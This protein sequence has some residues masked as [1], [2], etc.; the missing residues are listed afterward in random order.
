[1]KQIRG[2]EFQEVITVLSPLIKKALLQTSFEN[3]DD[4]QQE[5]YEFILKKI[6]NN[7]FTETVDFFDLLEKETI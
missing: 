2:E 3:R 4:L 7:T 6:I 1:V 5:I